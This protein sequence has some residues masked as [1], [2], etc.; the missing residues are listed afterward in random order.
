MAKAAVPITVSPSLPLPVSPRPPSPFQ[1][2]NMLTAII[3]FSLRYRV[4]VLI[5]TLGIIVAGGVALTHMDGKR[6]LHLDVFRSQ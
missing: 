3:D 2:Q 1:N 4:I 5:A 6:D